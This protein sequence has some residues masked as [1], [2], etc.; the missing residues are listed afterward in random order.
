MFLLHA[1]C[2]APYY[3]VP[4]DLFKEFNAVTENSS[5]KFITAKLN[6][7]FE[8][9]LDIDPSELREKKTQVQIVDVRRPEE[10]VGELGHIPGAELVTLDT[11]PDRIDELPKNRPIVFVCRSGGRS[12]QATAF[13]KSNGFEHVFNMQ[14]GM[15]AWNKAN[16]ETEDRNGN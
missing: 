8:D 10:W 13:A 15:I 3:V 5:V 2:K 9:V 14:G 1:K 6:P 12:G 11:L 16:F 4:G 7:N